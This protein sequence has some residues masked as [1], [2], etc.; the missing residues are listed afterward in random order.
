[1]V[2]PQQPQGRPLQPGDLARALEGDTAKRPANVSN[3]SSEKSSTA[4]KAVL[5]V[6][7]LALVGVG[8]AIAYLL[9]M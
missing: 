3:A 8:G 1:M 9:L 5:V 2:E 7:L 6:L 4:L